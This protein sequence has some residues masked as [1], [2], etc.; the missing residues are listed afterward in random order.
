M[1]RSSMFKLV[2]VVGL[3]L[4]SI[5]VLRSQAAAPQVRKDV[6]DIT[7]FVPFEIGGKY[8]RNGDKITIEEVHGTADTIAVG[9][10]YEI[11]GTYTLASHDKAD[12]AIEVTSSDTN[13]Y[14]TLKPQYM[15]VDK[16]DGHFTVYLYMWT[17]G[18]PH[19]SFYPADGESSFASVYFGT[20]DSVLNHASWLE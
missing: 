19:I 8:L 4:A 17:E 3:L 1:I 13:H 7:T 18:N 2:V 12:L 6:Y 9:G 14:P 11:K 16:G 10:L 20:G 5:L 15:K